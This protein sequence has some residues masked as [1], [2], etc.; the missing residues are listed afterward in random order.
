MSCGESVQVAR[1]R[2]RSFRRLSLSVGLCI[3][4]RLLAET[5]VPLTALKSV[6][7]WKLAALGGR[8]GFSR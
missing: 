6:L 5:A 4:Q 8:C 7:G 3:L 1:Y 2:A